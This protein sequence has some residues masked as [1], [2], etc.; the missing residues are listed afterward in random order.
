MGTTCTSLHV[1]RGATKPR[2]FIADLG[3]AYEKIGFVA[4]GDAAGGAHKRVIVTDDGQSKFVSI[5]DS[6]NALIDSGELKE[7]AVALSKRLKSVAVLTSVYDSDRFEFIVFHK[8]KQVDA[9]VSNADDHAGGLKY[10]SPKRRLA[11]WSELFLGPDLLR[12]LAAQPPV[13]L[14]PERMATL[15]QRHRDFEE[16]LGRAAQTVGAFAEDLLA[17]WCDVAGLDVSQALAGFQDML[18]EAEPA[19]LALVLRKAAAAGSGAAV[20]GAGTAPAVELLAY[21]SDD[22]CPYLRYYPAAWPIPVGQTQR[23]KWLVLSQGAGFSGL[24]LDLAI[25]DPAAVCI[26]KVSVHAFPFYNGQIT[27]PSA[28]AAWET[29]P[30][31]AP[32]TGHLRLAVEPLEIAAVE[33]EARKHI[34]LLVGLELVATD[35]RAFTVR[36]AIAARMPATEFVPL[37][38]LRLRARRPSFVPTMAEP[39]SDRHAQAI[40]RLNEPAVLSMVAI[41][42]DD[43]EAVRRSIRDWSQACLAELAAPAGTQLVVDTQKHMSPVSF[44]VAKTSKALPLSNAPKDKQ[45]PRLFDLTNDYQTVMLG[46]VPPGAGWPV[47]GLSW[48]SALRDGLRDD[49]TRASHLRA[50]IAN[51]LP[52]DALPIARDDGPTLSFALWIVNEPAV[53]EQLSV[54][55]DRIADLFEAWMANIAPVQAAIAT[56]AWIPEFDL[57]ERYNETLYE[58]ASDLDWFRSGLNGMLT[59]RAWSARRLRTLGSTLWLGLELERAI[60]ANVLQQ[61]ASLSKPGASL[62]IALRPEATLGQLEAALD[63]IL[64]KALRAAP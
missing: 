27:A 42:N 40:L 19:P 11:A 3:K 62:K 53:F 14:D 43:G 20:A 9:V 15:A 52:P 36:A 26:G 28:L 25:D 46:I 33:P 31:R 1:L 56:S 2:G 13:R 38:P 17:A 61:I 21:R 16:R 34:I 12:S 18:Q 48:Q 45:W 54:S 59:S 24:L 8:G 49:A 35:A 55:A 32:Q 58:A 5:Y 4:A 64:P 22:D 23:L 51:H 60:D 57:Y 29:T 50:T 10:L 6:D 39:H 63:P 7:L 44:R 47:A 37:P 41:L 30:P